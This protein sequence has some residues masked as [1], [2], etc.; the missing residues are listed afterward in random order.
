[1]AKRR[2]RRSKKQGKAS[3]FKFRIKPKTKK[4]LIQSGIL[5]ASLAVVFVLYSSLQIKAFNWSPSPSKIT[6]TKVTP[7]RA[8]IPAVK[9]VTPAP[10]KKA[11][12]TASQPASE[13][14]FKP[15]PRPA[16]IV[17]P[18]PEPRVKPLPPSTAWMSSKPK[19]VFVIDDIG[20]TKKQEYLFNRLG[21]QI[22]Y[23]IL[24]NLRYSKYFADLSTDTGAEVILH[25][26]LEASDNTIP[27]PGLI[28]DQME[29]WH[30]RDV[31][32]RNLNAIPHRVGMNNHMG[33]GSTQ[34]P[35]LMQTIMTELKRRQFFYLDSYTSSKSVGWKTAKSMGMPI[36][37]RDVFLDNADNQPAIRKQVEDLALIAR[38]RGY[39]IGIGHDRYNTLK[40]ISEEIPK[41]RAA[42]FEI[43]SLRDII[44]YKQQKGDRL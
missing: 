22:T 43:V 35:E 17:R 6:A 36:L 25:Q 40:V 1:M 30:V 27:G 18:E 32:N 44:R 2:R 4:Q 28:T 33:S 29:S 26:P 11:S 16:P 41:L 39:A 9:K 12:S 7:P 8:P 38:K 10:I 24:P 15:A 23:A 42:G 5:I 13:L 34:N 37:K 3:G 14:L 19:I 31:L 21:S 20:H